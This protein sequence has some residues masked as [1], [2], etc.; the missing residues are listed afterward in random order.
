[1]TLLSSAVP[2]GLPGN[3]EQIARPELINHRGHR[4]HRESHREKQPRFTFLSL[5]VSVLFVFSVVKSSMFRSEHAIPT[6]EIFENFHILK[7]I[8]RPSQ[9]LRL[10][11]LIEGDFEIDATAG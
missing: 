3:L 8:E 6:R 1:M 10:R 9:L 11:T 4:E 7:R 5:P 2:G